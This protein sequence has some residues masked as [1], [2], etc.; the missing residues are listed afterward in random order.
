ML[1]MAYQ[2]TWLSAQGWQDDYMIRWSLAENLRDIQG[3]LFV[4][5]VQ[6][7]IPKHFTT[8]LMR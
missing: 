2:T 7:R 5:V 3:D 1:M 4:I 8:M 6:I